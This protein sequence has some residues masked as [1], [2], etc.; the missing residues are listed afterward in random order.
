VREAP[1]ANSNGTIALY[2]A[3]LAH[4]IPADV[5]VITTPFNFIISVKSILYTSA[6]PLFYLDTLRVL[7]GISIECMI[8]YP[9]SK[10][11]P[12]C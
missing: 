1:I 10:Q 9:V 2:L 6:R 11:E 4:A 8:R 7:C 3:L 5:E 12:P